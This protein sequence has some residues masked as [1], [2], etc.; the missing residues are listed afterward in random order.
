MATGEKMSKVQEIPTKEQ[1]Q[2]VIMLCKAYEVGSNYLIKGSQL[3]YSGIFCET[4]GEMS[5][6]H[7]PMQKF[8]WEFQATALALPKHKI[9]DLRF[10]LRTSYP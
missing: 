1:F 3:F 7:D 5:S 8:I 9:I 2:R 10:L 4:H 6:V